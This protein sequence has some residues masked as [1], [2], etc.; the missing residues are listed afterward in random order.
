MATQAAADENTEIFGLDLGHGETALARTRLG[1][2]GE[3]APVEIGGGR[4]LV[5]AVGVDAVG[6]IAIGREV[7]ARAAE[8]TESFVRFKAPAL[9]RHPV[10]GRAI[11][12]FVRGLRQRLAA[13]R[14]LADPD[15]AL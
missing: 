4:S 13:D 2:A 5:T 8:L 6:R 9:D 3:P 1:A 7:V 11:R 12:L 15:R 14:L 10:A